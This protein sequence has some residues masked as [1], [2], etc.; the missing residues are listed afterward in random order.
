MYAEDRIPPAHWLVA[1]LA[2][3][4]LH[5]LLLLALTSA[6]LA[7][8]GE[9]HER[10]S[11][12]SRLRIALGTAGTEPTSPLTP[13]PQ[14]VAKA[15]PKAPPRPSAARTR[16]PA[17]SRVE[18][19]SQAVADVAAGPV[20]AA[21]DDPRGA[22]LQSGVEASPLGTSRSDYFSALHARV[23]GTLDYPRRARLDSTQGTVVLRLRIDRD[24]RIQSSQVVESSGSRVL[25]RHAARIARRAAPFGRVPVHFEDDDLAFELPVEF[26]LSD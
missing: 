23:Q 21:G 18:T 16:P 3:I 26:T 15:P 11:T 8:I 6:D 12:A 7:R 25:D 20:T 19:E 17:P 4:G 5:A 9:P 22:A 1:G 13:P 10:P 24:G 14:P 2:A